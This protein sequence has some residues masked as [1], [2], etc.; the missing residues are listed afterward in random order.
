MTQRTVLVRNETRDRIL[1]ESAEVADS[2]AKRKKGL[3]GRNTFVRGEGLWIVPCEGV[4]TWGMKFPIDVLYLDKK[5]RIRKVL[6][7]MMPWRLSV[8]LSAHSVLE[9]PAAVIEET[10]TQPGDQLDLSWVL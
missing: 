3:L 1:A 5:S 8:C 10:G 6:R 2:S 9:L 7:A 4:H